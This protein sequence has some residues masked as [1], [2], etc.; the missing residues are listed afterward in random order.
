[1][2]KDLWFVSMKNTDGGYS[3]QLLN[4]DIEERQEAIR[5]CFQGYG[6]RWKIEE[7]HRHMK[8]EYELE[9]IKLMNF[10]A[11]QNMTTLI[12]M[13]MYIVYTEIGRIS[14]K[15]LCQAGPYRP[16]DLKG[17]IYYKLGREIAKILSNVS[18]RKIVYTN[19]K[20]ENKRQL[21]LGFDTF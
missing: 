3:Y 13:A 4:V 15:V 10:S 18:P 20:Q 1:M 12:M 7:Y 16:E 11:L 17:F 19:K 5:E 21:T 2:D 8:Q 14:L 6:Y 9:E